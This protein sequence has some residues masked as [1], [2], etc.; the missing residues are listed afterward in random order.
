MRVGRGRQRYRTTHNA[1]PPRN[2]QPVEEAGRAAVAEMIRPASSKS[3][4]LRRAAMQDGMSRTPT[5]N[6]TSFMLLFLKA[7]AGPEAYFFQNAGADDPGVGL[8]HLLEEGG[9]IVAGDDVA[10][11]PIELNEIAD[12]V[13]V[14]EAGFTLD[15]F[16]VDPVECSLGGVVWMGDQDVFTFGVAMIEAGSIEGKEEVEEL[17][18]GGGFVFGG[19]V[20]GGGFDPLTEGEGVVEVFAD[21]VALDGNAKAVFFEDAEGLRGGDVKGL[22][23]SC[24][25]PE[26][27]GG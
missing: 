27:A 14:G 23:G 22:H 11:G 4:R 3:T 1:N 18:D 10:N 6:L 8:R 12:D 15:T 24:G 13:V 19:F 7:A 20:E 16:E 5:I 26:A 17:S 25:G 2:H 21:H 9:A